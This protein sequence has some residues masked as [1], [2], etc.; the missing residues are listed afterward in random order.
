MQVAHELHVILANLL[1]DSYPAATSLAL[2]SAGHCSFSD[3][4]DTKD[5]VCKHGTRMARVRLT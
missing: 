1:Q 4:R 3:Y 5:S 2:E